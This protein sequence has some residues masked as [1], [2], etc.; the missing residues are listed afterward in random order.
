MI[1][2][3]AISQKPFPLIINSPQ[4]ITDVEFRDHFFRPA[5]NK[6]FQ[7]IGHVI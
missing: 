4:V 7:S 3:Y 1:K 2:N 5:F 6:L